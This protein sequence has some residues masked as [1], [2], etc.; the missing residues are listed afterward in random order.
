MLQIA[1][2][3]LPGS[4]HIL[5]PAHCMIWPCPDYELERLRRL[6]ERTRLEE[7]KEALRQWLR[8][9][10]VSEHE[11]CPRPF[12][13]M[14]LARPPFSTLLGGGKPSVQDV[15]RQIK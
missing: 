4:W 7:E 3:Q 15:L 11:V 6:Q 8:R 2:P 10:G 13:P 5:P 14:P 12:L 9:H 1:H